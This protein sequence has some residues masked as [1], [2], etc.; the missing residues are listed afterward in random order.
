[1][2]MAAMV[3]SALLLLQ[4]AD[5]KK[6]GDLIRDLGAEEFSVR[7]RA[8]AELRKMGE[9]AAPALRQALE[10]KDPEK[11]LRAHRVLEDLEKNERQPNQDRPSRSRARMTRERI[12]TMCRAHS[13]HV[14]GSLVQ[15]HSPARG[16][17]RPP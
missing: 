11:A 3:L 7:E 6:A 16:R 12:T 17:S 5:D 1:M 13:V 10:D 14:S 4:G 2:T 8:E 9:S 15:A